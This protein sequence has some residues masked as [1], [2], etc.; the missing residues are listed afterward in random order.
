[1][2]DDDQPVY[3]YHDGT[4]LDGERRT[5]EAADP[6]YAGDRSPELPR[7]CA[8]PATSQGKNTAEYSTKYNTDN[9]TGQEQGGI[10]LHKDDAVH[11]RPPARGNGSHERSGNGINS[12]A[13]SSVGRTT[14]SLP[15]VK[16]PLTSLSQSTRQHA[17]LYMVT[18]KVRSRQ[19]P[20]H[21]ESFEESHG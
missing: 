19:A 21:V 4:I 9:R 12:D 8:N 3:M 15:S 2:L 1:M 7:G 5:C 17:R 10:E 6:A 20:S 16:R 18:Q 14:M 13:P 11:T